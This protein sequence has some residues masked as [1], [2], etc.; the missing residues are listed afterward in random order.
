L[1]ASNVSA[2]LKKQTQKTQ[3]L[4]QHYDGITKL[5]VLHQAFPAGKLFFEFPLIR[6]QIFPNGKKSVLPGF[7]SELLVIIA[8][9]L[10]QQRYFN[11]NVRSDRLGFIDINRYV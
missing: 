7:I 11:V 8:V 2:I 9:E 6:L 1:K 4:D 3:R 10:R 5:Q